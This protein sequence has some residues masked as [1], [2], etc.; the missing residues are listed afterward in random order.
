MNV[1][2]M[3]VGR[4]TDALIAE[5]V[6]G[7][8]SIGTDGVSTYGKPPVVTREL[9]DHGTGIKGLYHVPRYSTDIAAAWQAVSFFQSRGWF[10]SVIFDPRFNGTWKCCFETQKGGSGYIEA[11]T[12]PLAICLAALKAAA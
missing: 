6:M 5:K 7:W 8:K 1:D 2:T 9:Q 3:P 10:V 4:E 12:A 11:D